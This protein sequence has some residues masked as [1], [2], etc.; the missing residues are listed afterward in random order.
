M[1]EELQFAHALMPHLERAAA[2]QTRLG[3]ALAVARSVLDALETTQAPVLI[4]DGRGRVVHASAEAERLLCELDGLSAGASGL[5]AATPALSSRLVAMITRAV[6]VSG[7]PRG[8]GT[9]HLPRPS[10]RPELTLVAVP[11]PPHAACPDAH[12]PAVLLQITDPLAHATPHRA[13][14]AQAFELTPAEADVAADLLDGLSVREV[15]ARS[16]RSI[17]TVRTHLASVLAKTGTS[18]QSELVRL[19]M[20][21]PRTPDC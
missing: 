16:G 15:A 12:H 6:G 7:E 21:L 8:A 3:D 17:A 2:V 4:L 13:L 5:R 20:R 1:Y 19:L 14:L 18:R 11:L 10:G 9:L